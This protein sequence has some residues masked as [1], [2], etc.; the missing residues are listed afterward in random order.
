[1]L[2]KFISD[3]NIFLFYLISPRRD[4]ICDTK[5]VICVGITK[6]KVNQVGCILKLKIKKLNSTKSVDN[7]KNMLPFKIYQK[8]VISE[9]HRLDK[10]KIKMKQVKCILK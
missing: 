5:H 1:M 7:N 8:Y 6:M 4:Y 3:N 2:K 9:G 10:T